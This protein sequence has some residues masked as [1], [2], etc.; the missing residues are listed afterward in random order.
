M[1]EDLIPNDTV[2]EKRESRKKNRLDRRKIDDETKDEVE[3]ALD[4]IRNPHT[5]EALKEIAHILTGDDRFDPD[6]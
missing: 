3:N 5:R 4:Q 2:D 6:K 1:D